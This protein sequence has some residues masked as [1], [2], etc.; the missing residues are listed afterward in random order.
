MQTLN[1]VDYTI[2]AVLLLSVLISL[3]RG[4]IREAL[5]LAAWIIAFWVAL[6]FSKNFSVYLTPYLHNPTTSY[7]TAFIILFIACLLLVASINFVITTM[8]DKTGISG[9]DRL[10]GVVFGFVRGL[11]FI[12]IL[13]LAARM[14]PFPQNNV[15]KESQLIP[16]FAPIENCLVQYIPKNIQEELEQRHHP[17][18][19]PESAT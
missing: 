18:Q 3:A 14:T 12:A 10:L 7:V 16:R 9:T 4:F 15:W 17:Q 2:I 8:M 19:Q 5:S 13:M 1:W 11:L 6:T